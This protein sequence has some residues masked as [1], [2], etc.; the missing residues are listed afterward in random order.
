MLESE[1]VRAAVQRVGWIAVLQ[2]L[3]PDLATGLDRPGQHIPCPVHQDSV[4]GF[5]FFRDVD[6]SGGG[7]CNTCGAKPD[8]FALLQWLFGWTFPTA[9]AE[10]GRVVGLGDG[11]RIVAPP[12]RVITRKPIALR[13]SAD[14]AKTRLNAVWREAKPVRSS[15]AAVALR[16]CEL[17]GIDAELLDPRRF[18][19]SPALPYWEVS[20]TGDHPVLLGKFPALL[21]LVTDAADRPITIHRTYLAMDGHGKAP[22]EKA[23]KLMPHVAGAN[24]FRN[25]AVRLFEPTD[26][27]GVTEGIETGFAVHSLFNEPVWACLSDTLMESFRPPE[28]VKVLTIWADNDRKRA[29]QDAAQKLAESLDGVCRVEIR[30]PVGVIPPGAKGIDWADVWDEERELRSVA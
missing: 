9:L 18:R 28:G 25:V 3:A 7:V 10:V 1:D 16:Y 24:G 5:R 14:K 19:F 26:R 2:T 8:G 12:R 29:G 4:D 27:L 17:R 30:L 13:E 21:A 15:E 6:I 22:V 23:K 20:K 11:R